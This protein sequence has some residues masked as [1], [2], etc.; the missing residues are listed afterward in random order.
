MCKVII[1]RKYNKNCDTGRFELIYKGSPVP[2]PNYIGIELKV[3]GHSLKRTSGGGGG[4]AQQAGAA[5]SSSS[6]SSSS[7]TAAGNSDAVQTSNSPVNST[8]GSVTLASISSSAVAHNKSQ[9]NVSNAIGASS[10]KSQSLSSLHAH[11]SSTSTSRLTRKESTILPNIHET[12][13]GSSSLQLHAASSAAAA[14]AYPMAEIKVG[15]HQS[16]GLTNHA[17]ITRHNSRQILDELKLKFSTTAMNF[18]MPKLAEVK[19]QPPNMVDAGSHHHQPTG[20]STT[21]NTMLNKF[22]LKQRIL[23]SNDLEKQ[24][25]QIEQSLEG[26]YG[27][28]TAAAAAA[29]AAATSNGNEA[30]RKLSNAGKQQKLKSRRMNKKKIL[31]SISSVETSDLNDTNLLSSLTFRKANGQPQ[32]QH[33]QQQQHQQQQQQQRAGLSRSSNFPAASD[34]LPK[35]FISS[36]NKTSLT[37]HTSVSVSLS[38]KPYLSSKDDMQVKF[39]SESHANV[40]N[41]EGPTTQR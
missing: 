14:A 27:G 9:S 17:T 18:H 15:T 41:D 1:D 22:V 23:I 8:S 21:T 12:L 34:Q 38:A 37:S 30:N 31:M 19:I 39:R 35:L 28:S 26:T 10:S 11:H 5:P 33:P 32:P 40:P 20:H 3:D 6:S 7:T 13:T 36:V 4:G 25:R 29:A 16:S 2:V 24:R